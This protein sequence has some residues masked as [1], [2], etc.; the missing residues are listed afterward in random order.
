[1]TNKYK[2]PIRKPKFYWH[3][4]IWL[5]IMTAFALGSGDFSLELYLSGLVG[6]LVSYFTQLGVYQVQEKEKDTNEN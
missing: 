2:D 5:L 6:A 1:M 4:L 3:L